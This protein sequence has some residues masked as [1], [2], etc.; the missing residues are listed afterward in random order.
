MKKVEVLFKSGQKV[1]TTC[2]DLIMEWKYDSVITRM[3]ILNGTPDVVYVNLNDVNCVL[4]TELP[5]E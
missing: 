1:E 2:D 4:V 5:E 3:V